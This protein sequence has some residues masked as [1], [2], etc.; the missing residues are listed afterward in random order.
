MEFP[1]LAR[2]LISLFLI[3]FFNRILKQLTIAVIIGTIVLSIWSGHT[4]AA[5]WQI[6]ADRAFS[7]NN[8]MLLI[9]VL[10]II[11]LSSQM[12]FSGIMKQLVENFSKKFSRR[13]TMAVLP[14]A[15]G[16][17]PMP[18]GAVFSAPLIDKTD[19]N[20]KIPPML[21]TKINY[22]FRHIW[23]YWWPLYPG[24]LLA[25]EIS[26]IPLTHLMLIN[27]PLTLMTVI[28]G[29]V[30]FLRRVP[31][32]EDRSEETISFHVLL[33]P[34]MPV[35]IIIA[36][37]AIIKLLFPALT[38]FSK[39]LPVIIGVST[40]QLYLQ[41]SRALSLSDWKKIITNK[42]LYN[43]ATV[44]LFIRIYGAFIE[45]ELPGG[46]AFMDKISAEL[47]TWH[48][49]VLA[50]IMLLPFISGFT[51]GI[52]I[53]FVGTSFPVVMNLLPSDVTAGQ[54]YATVIL[55]Y[56]VGY[57]GMILSPVHI[58]L[59]VTNKYFKTDLLE[60]IYRLLAPETVMLVWVFLLYFLYNIIF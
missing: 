54:L 13:T 17:L 51:S 44:V 25:A 33:K 10:Q 46:I 40:A 32:A 37:Y 2:L 3:L 8:I 60:S 53:G 41:Y 23:E 5:I 7:I 56:G 52:A 12:S 20:N 36:V 6:S 27:F 22:W 19:K 31:A 45:A 14:A 38:A 42:K 9:I 29:A 26:E 48:I 35:I 43:L 47:N 30:F 4:P 50:I 59:V 15:V 58:C 39:Y 55:A 28:V 21:K 34:L 11:I 1:F 49:P 24:I 18:G 57:I 16:L